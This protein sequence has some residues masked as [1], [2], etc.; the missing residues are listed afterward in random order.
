MPTT[1]PQHDTTLASHSKIFIT[2]LAD[3]GYCGFSFAE[4]LQRP[5]RPSE[6]NAYTNDSA[7]ASNSTDNRDA[8]GQSARKQRGTQRPHIYGQQQ[9]CH[10]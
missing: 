6:T 3:H 10:A 8:C 1:R 9:Q 2:K 5:T 4:W 7:N